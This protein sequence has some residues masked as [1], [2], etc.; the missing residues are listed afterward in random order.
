MNGVSLA[1]SALRTAVDSSKADAMAE[2]LAVS[3]QGF[4][5]VEAFWKSQGVA[6]AMKIAQ[7]ARGHVE[8]IGKAAAG[9]DWEA[10]KRSTATLNQSCQTCH[11]TCRERLDDGSFRV[12]LPARKPASR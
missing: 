7:E 4:T 6:E 2:H 10:A 8:S 3:R 12:R 5:Q 9:G 11:T 1:V